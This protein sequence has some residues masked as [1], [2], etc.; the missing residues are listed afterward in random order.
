MGKL[1]LR[2]FSGRRVG[3]ILL[4]TLLAAGLAL[5]GGRTWWTDY[6]LKE[7][8]KAL[9]RQRFPEARFHL[10]RVLWLRPRDASIH[11]L[12]G[13][14]ARRAGD[15]EAARKHYDQCQKFQST[16]SEALSLE[17]AMLKAQTQDVD[18]VFPMLW[19]YV[20]RG[21][22]NSPLILEALCIGCLGTSRYGG[23]KK[24]LDR[25][26]RMEPENVQAH[27]LNGLYLNDLSLPE[28]AI[29]SFRRALELD[30]SRVDIR[31]S[32]A[33]TLVDGKDPSQAMQQYEEVLRLET[34]HA[35]A[36]LGLARAS[37]DLGQP[38]RAVRILEALLQEEPDNADAL[39]ERGRVALQQ[40]ANEDAERWLRAALNA[41]P[42]HFRAS[43]TL[44]SCLQR[45]GKDKEASELEEKFQRL[46]A[47]HRRINEILRN[48]LAKAPNDP[49][50]YYELGRLLFENDRKKQA[51]SWL[52][53]ALKLDPNHRQSHELLTRYYR[54]I[55]D[56]KGVESHQG[57]A[58]T[59]AA[60]FSSPSQTT[61]LPRKP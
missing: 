44:L 24:C 21:H 56:T 50:L 55:G 58:T 6:H 43:Y 10:G 31:C 15:A 3:L 16:A 35:H 2:H 52:Y 60:D 39:C 41:N 7:A 34:R 13:R 40:G 47:N 1:S 53:Q 48:E 49:N 45:L 38:D 27:L 57:L 8:Q 12:A 32:L 54:E 61:L 20:E 22:P 42:A 4:L 37:L 18:A 19:T 11:L 59:P 9:A 25:W 5:W 29:S 51:V 14:A 28:E 33:D 46:E 30:P 17:Q 23:V 36:R 26:L